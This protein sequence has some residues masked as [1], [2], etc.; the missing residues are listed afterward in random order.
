[1][2]RSALLVQLCILTTTLL[3]SGNILES[4]SDQFTTL[5][6]DK[7]LTSKEM[8]EMAAIFHINRIWSRRA[9]RVRK[10]GGKL[11]TCNDVTI[12][13][14]DRGRQILK[15]RACTALFKNPLRQNLPNQ[16]LDENNRPALQIFWISSPNKR[17]CG[18]RHHMRHSHISSTIIFRVSLFGYVIY[19][20]TD[21]LYQLCA[22]AEEKIAKPNELIIVIIA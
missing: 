22:S 3:F 4:N 19:S 9:R 10:Y 15:L 11:D 17:R 7:L 2:S 20:S 12:C 6:F 21:T 18:L 5:S 13:F 8:R 14:T 16:H 1:M